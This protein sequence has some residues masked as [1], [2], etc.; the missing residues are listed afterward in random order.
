M[1][2]FCWKLCTRIYNILFCCF[3]LLGLQ[4]QVSLQQDQKFR[5]ICKWSEH[6]CFYIWNTY[7]LPFETRLG[8]LKVS[9]CVF[10]Y[11][12]FGCYLTFSKNYS[13][14]AFFASDNLPTLMACSVRKGF[15]QSIC[16]TKEQK[17]RSQCLAIA[18]C[19]N[20]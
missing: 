4:F 19:W 1:I 13:N 12:F 10:L 15:N 20:L 8:V 14:L 5:E 7:I 6:Y 2:N 17:T 16:R 9:L 11:L 3:V 18:R